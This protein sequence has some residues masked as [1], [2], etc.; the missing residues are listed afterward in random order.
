MPAYWM[1]I[2]LGVL[3]NQAEFRSEKIDIVVDVSSSI[4]TYVVRNHSSDPVVGFEIPQHASYNFTV[5]KGWQHEASD[6]LFK[7]LAK[8]P[9]AA[10]AD[11]QKGEFSLRVSSAGA[12]LGAV[13]ARVV[14]RSGDAAVIRGVWAPVRRSRNY[15]LLVTATMVALVVA[16]A[17]IMATRDR[18]KRNPQRRAS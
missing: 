13:T 3:P 5:P 9:S 18:H 10:I 14:F 16:H 8:E 11:G 15:A 6:G 7:C 1:L 12:A 4:Y 2:L 17:V